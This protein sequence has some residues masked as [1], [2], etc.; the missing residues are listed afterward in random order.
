MLT[1]YEGIVKKGWG[2]ENI[3]VTNDDYCGK[4][5]H[6]RNGGKSSMHFHLDKKETWYVISGKYLIKFIEIGRAHV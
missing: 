5:L 3:F 1:R 4:I 6:F 2:H